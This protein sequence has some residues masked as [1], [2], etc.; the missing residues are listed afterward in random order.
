MLPR[1]AVTKPEV[2][3]AIVD[4]LGFAF[5]PLTIAPARAPP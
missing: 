5:T 4:H 3:A 2:T 1:A